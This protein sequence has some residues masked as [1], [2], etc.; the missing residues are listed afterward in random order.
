M[1][2][3]ADKQLSKDDADDDVEVPFSPSIFIPLTDP[4]ISSLQEIDTPAQGL[5]KADEAALSQRKSV[6][7]SIV[8]LRACNGA[9]SRAF[10]Q[11]QRIA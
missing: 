4:P 8:S 9:Y 3:G 6:V 10:I 1:K 2:R 5:Q 11:D 7:P